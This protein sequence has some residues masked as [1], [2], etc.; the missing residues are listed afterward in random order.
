MEYE[1]MTP[2]TTTRQ[3]SFLTFFNCLKLISESEDG[4]G[5]SSLSEDAG[6]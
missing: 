5:R 2:N 6:S 3:V 1:L 4:G